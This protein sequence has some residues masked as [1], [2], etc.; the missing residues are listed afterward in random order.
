MTSPETEAVSVKTLIKP[1]KGLKQPSPQETDFAAAPVKTLIKPWK[2]LKQKDIIRLS[3]SVKS[4]NPNKTL[5]GIKTGTSTP[6][7]PADI[8]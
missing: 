5:E 4:E 1:W 3:F 2:G 6:V 8:T 7:S